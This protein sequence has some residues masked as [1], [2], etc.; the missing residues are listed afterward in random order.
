MEPNPDLVDQLITQIL[1]DLETLCAAVKAH[2]KTAQN[3]NGKGGGDSS[4]GTTLANLQQLQHLSG[5]F[6]TFK[7]RQ[8]K[9]VSSM[10]RAAWEMNQ[11]HNIGGTSVDFALRFVQASQP[12]LDRIYTTPDLSHF[13]A[14][15]RNFMHQ[16]YTLDIELGKQNFKSDTW[17]SIIHSA[18]TLNE[19]L[20]HNY[21]YVYENVWEPSPP[22]N[23]TR[24]AGGDTAAPKQYENTD[25]LETVYYNSNDEMATDDDD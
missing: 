21:M 17:S 25:D 3:D 11:N 8:K 15:L 10:R 14:G 23:S 19:L 18:N 1:A 24:D 12:N 20:K 5:I 16:I 2:L 4:S 7:G 6:E 13:L 9:R 22:T